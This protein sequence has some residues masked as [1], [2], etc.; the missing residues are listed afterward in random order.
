MSALRIMRTTSP[1]ISATPR[2]SP[3]RAT[4]RVTT[5]ASRPADEDGDQVHPPLVTSTATRHRSVGHGH[6][7]LLARDR[8]GRAGR[9]LASGVVRDDGLA[10]VARRVSDRAVGFHD[11]AG[12]EERARPVLEGRALQELEALLGEKDGRRLSATDLDAAEGV[13]QARCDGDDPDRQ[14]QGG[15]Q[16]LDQGEAAPAA[17]WMLTRPEAATTTL[18]V[19]PSAGLTTT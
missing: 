15:D 10:A 19:R 5:P 6:P 8:R 7:D 11:G 14:D 1:R 18:R 4:G 16:D 13:V 9:A 3:R 2:S 17:Q 12:R